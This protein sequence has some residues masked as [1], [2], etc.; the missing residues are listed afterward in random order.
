MS[1]DLEEPGTALEQRVAALEAALDELRHPLLVA[2][3]PPLSEEETA[4]F[5]AEFEAA[6][7]QFPSH[8]MRLL[9]LS[10]P[11]LLSPETVRQL[12][13]ESV[14]VVKPGEVL[15]LVCPENRTADQIGEIQR[16]VSAWLEYNAPD[17]RVLVLP[18]GEMAVAEPE[19]A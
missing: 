19:P 2:E 18:Y 4:R 8:L 11:S 13:R 3:A 10:P 5:K 12:L 15:F 14:T 9:P 7:K 6:A 17:I 1:A 16:A